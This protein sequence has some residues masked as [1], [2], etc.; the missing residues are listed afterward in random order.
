MAFCNRFFILLSALLLLLSACSPTVETREAQESFSVTEA[1]AKAFPIDGGYAAYDESAVRLYF[2]ETLLLA[3]DFSVIYS[4]RPDD[5]TELG[6]FRVP[7]DEDRRSV[8]REVNAYLSEFKETYLPQAELYDKEQKVKLSDATLRVIGS[9][10]I[11]TVMSEK[12]QRP[13]WKNAEAL[14]L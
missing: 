9:Y 10:V 4:V 5:Y 1:L 11:Y 12:E 8:A 3:Q 2:R 13:F 7:D 14:L 6:V